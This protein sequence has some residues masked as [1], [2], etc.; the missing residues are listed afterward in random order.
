MG[1]A[2]PGSGATVN[3]G[4]LAWPDPRVLTTT[5]VFNEL[6][7]ASLDPSHKRTPIATIEEAIA[8]YKAGRM[9]IV[10]DDEDRENEGD[11]CMAAEKV[12]PEA[13]NF[14]ATEGRG[15][16]CLPVT[17]QKLRE[18]GLPMMVAE[19]TA[20]LGTA[21]TV[22]IDARHGIGSGISARDRAQTIL[23]VVAD[24]AAPSDIRTPGHIF[25]LRARDG[26]VLVRTGQTEAAVDLARLAGLKPA[27]VICEIM[28]ADGTMARLADL[29]RFAARFDLRLVTIADLI[30]Y[31]LQHD[32]LVHRV[33][34]APIT[35]RYGGEFRA[36]VYRSDVD[37]GEH[38][39][40][41]KGDIRPDEPTLVRA[42][43]E[44]LPG[45]VFAFVKRNTGELL[46]RAMQI[47]AEEGKGVVLYLRREQGTEMFEPRGDTG[48]ADED[49]DAAKPSTMSS[50][51]LKEFREY[52]IGAQILRDLGIGK[53]RLISNYRRRLVSLPGFGLEVV[54]TVP[55]DVSPAA[56]AETVAAPV[57]ATTPRRRGSARPVKRSGARS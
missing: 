30:Q 43:A 16:I 42:H 20:P 29:K 6:P 36:C 46:H 7:E 15:L 17:E 49:P 13:I 2:M 28:K 1:E 47:I 21:F 39:A 53:I 14:M 5:A 12:T 26:G 44:Y 22:S 34:E 3:R 40:L 27:G 35:S 54:E 33:A 51:R 4:N 45:D 56:S 8:E 31:R 41:V 48:G 52:G 11:L 18:L 32:S 50:G 23:T 38:L 25:P 55:L 24:G 10:M 57:H 19:N 9:V 37:G